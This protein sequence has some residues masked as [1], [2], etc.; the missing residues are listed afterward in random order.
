[1]GATVDYGEAFLRTFPDTFPGL[2]SDHN[3]HPPM[4]WSTS[5]S[6]GD[7]LLIGGWSVTTGW[8]FV[9]TSAAVLL[10]A[11]VYEL[12]AFARPL[13][14]DTVRVGA[15]ARDCGLVALRSF[16]GYTAMLVVMS[17]NLWLLVFAVLG[18]TLGH[19]IA[20]HCSNRQ[21]SRSQRATGIDA[22]PLLDRD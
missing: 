7:D 20:T 14:Q 18:A 11:V 15:F 12:L 10:L 4:I 19:G 8:Q 2:C 9:G 22:A 13:P 6:L 3:H 17:M 5:A 21:R 1:M 16:L